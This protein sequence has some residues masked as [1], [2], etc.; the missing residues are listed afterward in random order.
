MKYR[1]SLEAKL[2][3]SELI[4]FD[5]EP[6]NSQ[7]A[8]TVPHNY[9]P[10]FIHPDQPNV[11]VEAKGYFRGGSADTKKYLAVIKDNPDKELVF[12]FPDPNKKAYPQCRMRSDGTYLSMGDWCTMHNILYFK[13]GNLP[14]GFI[15]GRM[16]VETLRSYK[17]SLMRT[18]EI[19]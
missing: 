5:Y 17:K 13:V 10:D 18:G 9:F 11:I 14:I 8:Y 15:K 12:I 16:S 4:E 1:S 19:I 7:V 3:N 2:A 6:R